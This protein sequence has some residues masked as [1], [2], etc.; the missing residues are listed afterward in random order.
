[1]PNRRTIPAGSRTPRLETIVR[2]STRLAGDRGGAAHGHG[3]R[4]G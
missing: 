1:M 2:P 3:H 4:A